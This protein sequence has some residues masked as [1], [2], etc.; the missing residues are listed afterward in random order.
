MD[1]KTSTGKY[2]EIEKA[3][4]INYWNKYYLNQI[5]KEVELS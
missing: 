3:C 5:T 2:Y 1:S 4:L